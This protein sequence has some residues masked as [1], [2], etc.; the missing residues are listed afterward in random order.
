[1][2]MP[3]LTPEQLWDYMQSVVRSGYHLPIKRNDGEIQIISFA[4]NKEGNRST[5]WHEILDNARRYVCSCVGYTK[6]NFIKYA[7]EGNWQPLEPFMLPVEPISTKRVYIRED[8]DTKNFV[9]FQKS[10]LGDIVEVHVASVNET[11]I[12]DSHG[13]TVVFPNTFLIPVPDEGEV[14]GTSWSIDCPGT[15]CKGCNCT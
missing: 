7:T 3:T 12:K 14:K 1:M 8:I 2:N 11:V 15:H 4:E 6:E 9:S 10:V 5:L 13:F